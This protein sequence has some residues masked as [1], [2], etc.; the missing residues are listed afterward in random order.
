MGYSERFSLEWWAN[1][2]GALCMF[3]LH[4]ADRLTVLVCFQM[5]HPESQ[6]FISQ[7]NPYLKGGGGQGCLKELQSIRR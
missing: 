4:Q 6:R 3:L 1:D 5:G 7:M 2:A